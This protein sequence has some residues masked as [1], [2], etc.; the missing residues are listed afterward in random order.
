MTG[1]LRIDGLAA[2]ADP[3]VLAAIGATPYAEE[4]AAPVRARPR[5]SV[6]PSRR[7]AGQDQFGDRHGGRAATVSWIVPLDGSQ[8]DLARQRSRRPRHRQDLG[9][10]LERGVGRPGRL[11]LVAAAFIFWVVQQRKRRAHRHQPKAPCNTP[12]LG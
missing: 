9:H 7:A 3:D 4:V 5:Q 2:F 6:S 12:S 11:V 8:L 1:S 10:R